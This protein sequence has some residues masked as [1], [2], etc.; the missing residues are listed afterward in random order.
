MIARDRIIEVATAAVRPLDW[1]RAAWLGGSDAS[2]RTDAW[3]DVDLVLVTEDPRVDEAFAVVADAL[4]DAAGV[5]HRYRLPEPTWHGHSQEFYRLQDADPCHFV[6]L[7][8]MKAGAPDRLMEP[9]RHGRPL[10]LFDRD[11]LVAP[12]PLDR[13]ALAERMRRRCDELRQT[14]WIFQGL[15]TKAVHRG[16]A[17]DAL[18][19]YHAFAVKPLVELLRM[20]HCPDRF[21]FGLRYLDRDLPADL[22]RLVHELV[23]PPDLRAVE[24][25]RGRAER[26]FREAEEALDAGQWSLPA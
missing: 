22:M 6:D 11:G 14:F 7:V 24:E 21:D 15:I 19:R 3:S 16:D 10:V 1:V 5:T 23:L 17:P 4:E 8:V 25:Y 2:G 13:A 18:Q 9:E 26:L 20:R 12:A